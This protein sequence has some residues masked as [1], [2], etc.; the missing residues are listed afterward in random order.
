M[1]WCTVHVCSVFKKG[2]EGRSSLRCEALD[3]VFLIVPT[4]L[5]C[6]SYDIHTILYYSTCVNVSICSL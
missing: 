2:N 5:L 4:A 3:I 6:A 1:G